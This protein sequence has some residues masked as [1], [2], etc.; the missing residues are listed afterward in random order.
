LPAYLAALTQEPAL[1]GVRFDKLA[2]R[3]AALS[4]APAQ[5]I[6]E[7]DAPGLKLAALEHGK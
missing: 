5:L 6:F 7:L 1:D 4:E 3:R 2:M